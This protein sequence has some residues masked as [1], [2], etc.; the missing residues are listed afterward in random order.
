MSGKKKVQYY[1]WD[2]I[3]KR[4]TPYTVTIGKRSDTRKKVRRLYYEWK[5]ENTVL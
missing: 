5:K 4:N 1:R 3:L 2:E